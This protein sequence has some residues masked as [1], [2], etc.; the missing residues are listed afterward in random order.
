[1]GVRV[2]DDVRGVDDLRGN[3]IAP[4]SGDATHV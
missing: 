2:P 1:M 4:F 3:A